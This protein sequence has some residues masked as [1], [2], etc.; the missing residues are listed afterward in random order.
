MQLYAERNVGMTE[1]IRKIVMEEIRPRTRVDGGD[2]VFDSYENGVIH[3][4][5]YGDCA[6]C[7]CCTPELST[8]IAERVSK[9]LGIEVK[10]EV[11]KK[12]PYYAR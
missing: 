5:A 3:V 11:R 1:Q 12:V 4:T 7:P 6:K 2:I 10:V 8:W 9:Q